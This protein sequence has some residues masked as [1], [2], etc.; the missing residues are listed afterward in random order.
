M[1]ARFE[2]STSG[3]TEE[4]AAGDSRRGEAAVAV[5]SAIAGGEARPSGRGFEQSA[6]AGE[7]QS[8]VSES[9]AM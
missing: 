8:G 1:S 7:S 9:E 3:Q 6:A 4:S 2:R 5:P